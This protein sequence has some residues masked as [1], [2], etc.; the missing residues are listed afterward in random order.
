[1]LIDASNLE[2]SVRGYL[3]DDD[4]DRVSF[5]SGNW[6]GSRGDRSIRYL[7]RAMVDL[8][9]LLDDINTLVG[10]VPLVLVIR[11]CN[12]HGL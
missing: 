5:L 9:P 1:M 6:L 7:L 11:A 12:D 2:A 4:A 10:Y 3:F 8:T